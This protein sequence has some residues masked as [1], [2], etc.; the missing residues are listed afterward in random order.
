MVEQMIAALDAKLRA[1]YPSCNSP[2]ASCGTLRDTQRIGLLTEESYSAIGGIAGALAQPRQLGALPICRPRRRAWCGRIFTR[3][4]TP[5]RTRA[6]VSLGRAAR[7]VEPA[8]RSPAAWSITSWPPGSWWSRKPAPPAR[9]QTIPCPRAASM[10]MVEIVHESLITRWPLLRRWLD[11]NQGRR[12]VPR[13]AAH[14][15]QAVGRSRPAQRA[16]CGAARPWP[17]PG[18]GISATTASCRRRQERLPR[19]R[20]CPGRASRAQAADPGGRLPSAFC[21]CSSPPA[22]VALVLIRDAE[23]TRH[24]AGRER[25]ASRRARGQGEARAG[26]GQ[27]ARAAGGRAEGRAC[28]R[29][30]SR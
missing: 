9:R 15:G 28:Q 14:R 26:R 10:P 20:L 8:G 16:F 6:L 22:A 3:L 5:D 25:P 17:R 18:G 27:G 19:R 2:P 12:R 23:Q 30:R 13:S 11:E 29:V 7:A 4:V 24:R 21:P 1:R